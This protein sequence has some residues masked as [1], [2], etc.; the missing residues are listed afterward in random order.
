[1]KT[2]EKINIQKS[3][4]LR[5]GFGTVRRL[6]SSGSLATLPRSRSFEALITMQHSGDTAKRWT[7]DTRIKFSWFLKTIA[8][9]C[10]LKVNV[11]CEYLQK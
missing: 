3:V 5:L 7:G 6:A 10:S 2:I 1:M 11:H 9:R 4:N 8:N